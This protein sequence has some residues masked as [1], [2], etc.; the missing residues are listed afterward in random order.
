MGILIVDDSLDNLR[1][2]QV[3]LE[4][5]GH[6]QVVTARSAGEAFARLGMKDAAGAAAGIDVILMD[7]RMPGMDGIEACRRIKADERFRDTPVIMVTGQTDEKDLEAAFNAGAT[8]YLTKPVKVVELLARLHAALALK[9]EMD[10]RKLREQE[11]LRATLQLAELNRELHRLS[12]LDGLTGIAN[13]RSFDDGLDRDWRRA[14]RT[15]SP[16]ALLMIDIDS[17]KAY[18]D[19]YG[20]QHGDASLK[21]VAAALDLTLNRP[22]DWVARYGGE[23]FVAV[24]PD[25]DAR[26][27]A[28]VAEA[29][30]ARVEALGIVHT[31]SPFQENLTVSLGGAAMVPA[32]KSSPHGLISAA[33]QALYRAKREG[34]NRARVVD[35]ALATQVEPVPVR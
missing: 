33:D 28:V 34:R 7:I 18:N 20:H 31:H 29:L 2:L 6:H 1:P 10:C 23:E 27:A 26:G 30:R 32:P 21:E 3:L 25:T 19:T 11:L 14:A 5:A 15:A 12:R 22:G 17:F 35:L 24:L 16:L 4:A 9:R 13:R 8:D